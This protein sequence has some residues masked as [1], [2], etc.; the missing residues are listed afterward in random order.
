MQESSEGLGDEEDVSVAVIEQFDKVGEQVIDSASW[1][2]LAGCTSSGFTT[3]NKATGSR[4]GIP[5][6][7]SKSA[8]NGAG[9]Y[10]TTEPPSPTKSLERRPP[11]VGSV[12]IE[13]LRTPE[14]RGFKDTLVLVYDARTGCASS[15]KLLAENTVNEAECASPLQA[16]RHADAGSMSSLVNLLKAG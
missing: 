11:V 6:A 12:A 15:L 13:T 8:P 1:D 10:P 4:S 3:T 5:I 2:L 9:L 7:P 16:D 14:E